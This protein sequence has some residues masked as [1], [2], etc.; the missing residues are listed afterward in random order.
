MKYFLRLTH[1]QHK[2]CKVWVDVES[3]AAMVEFN[4][5]LDN[6]AGTA[7]YLK[8]NGGCVEVRESIEEINELGKRWF[9]AK[10]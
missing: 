3:I 4:D 10:G 1:W 8:N 7:V 2:N 6:F 5:V 9:D